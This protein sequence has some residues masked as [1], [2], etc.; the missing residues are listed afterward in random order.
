MMRPDKLAY[1]LDADQMAGIFAEWPADMKV[2]LCL[3]DAGGCQVMV[4]HEGEGRGVLRKVASVLERPLGQFVVVPETKG[5]P[6]RKVMFSEEQKMLTLVADAYDLAETATDYAINYRYAQD[7]GLNPETMKPKEKARETAEVITPTFRHRE[8]PPLAAP[9][10]S[11]APVRPRLR[12]SMGGLAK[13]PRPEP[14]AVA[15][16]LDPNVTLGYLPVEGL[17][18]EECF[19]LDGQIFEQDDCIRIVISRERMSVRTAPI[20]VTN[21]RFRDDF[22]RFML[23]RDA[24][25][26]WR[27]GDAVVLDIPIEQFPAALARRYQQFARHAEVTITD[28][29]IFVGP[30]SRIENWQPLDSRS[31]PLLR[32]VLTPARA[33]VLALV[34]VGAVAGTI[35]SSM[36]SDGQRIGSLF[37]DRASEPEVT[38]FIGAPLDL[39]G[40]M[41]RQE[42]LGSGK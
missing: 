19:F 11:R 40:T 6:T 9:R 10:V 12:L 35:L 41:A 27:Q 24:L 20:R 3:D 4:Y 36:Q 38:R 21:V 25:P 2:A 5:Y 8:K 1:F 18:R 14:V 33:A 30:G 37:G 16:P 13:K 29:G 26:N 31:K 17:G 32:R 23:P 28:R 22:S 39:I 15:A 42:A 7:Q 34:G